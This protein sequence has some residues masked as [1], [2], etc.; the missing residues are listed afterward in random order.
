MA[1]RFTTQVQTQANVITSWFCCLQLQLIIV[2]HSRIIPSNQKSYHNISRNVFHIW[3][4]MSCFM[5]YWSYLSVALCSVVQNSTQSHGLYASILL[6][7]I[8]KWWICYFY[9]KY[10]VYLSTKDKFSGGSAETCSRPDMEPNPA[11]PL[12]TAATE[13]YRGNIESL[14]SAPVVFRLWV[15]I[16]HPIIAGYK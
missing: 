7:L 14:S 12:T 5:F 1:R 6:T 9:S 15:R 11:L 2:M 13:D 3:Y 16:Q 8:L 10:C 4:N